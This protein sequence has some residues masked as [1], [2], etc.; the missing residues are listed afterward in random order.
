M[1]EYDRF[2]EIHK[3]LVELSSKFQKDSS[4]NDKYYN[5]V[6]SDIEK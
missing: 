2:E 6:K 4:G 5:E 1:S 3:E